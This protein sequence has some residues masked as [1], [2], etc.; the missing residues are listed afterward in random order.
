MTPGKGVPAESMVVY[1]FWARVSTGGIVISALSVPEV[2]LQKVLDTT[3]AMAMNESGMRVEF[4]LI[5][6]ELR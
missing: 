4:L 6:V 2:F 5:C 1:H 3:K